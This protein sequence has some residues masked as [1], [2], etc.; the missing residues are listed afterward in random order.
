MYD[1]LDIENYKRKK[2]IYQLNYLNDIK[3]EEKVKNAKIEFFKKLSKSVIQHEYGMFD[4]LNEISFLKLF[5]EFLEK[6]QKEGNY[7]K[8]Q[9]KEKHKIQIQY[10]SNY[11]YI[12]VQIL[13]YFI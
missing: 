3:G 9:I 5:F 12:Q 1:E 6:E 8:L 11:T 2:F 13:L 4:E 10:L 7:K